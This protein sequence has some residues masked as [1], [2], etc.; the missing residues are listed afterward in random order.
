MISVVII[1]KNEEKNIGECLKSVAWCDEKIVIDDY[2]KDNTAEIAEKSGAKVIKH[3]LINFSDQRNFGLEKARNDWVLFVDADERVSQALWYEI[4]HSI[5]NT[6]AKIDGFYIRRNDIMWGKM[7]RY[8]ESSGIKLMR[9]AR[10]TAGKWVGDVHE[11]WEISG[12]SRVLN[13]SLK[14]YPHQS[15]A[16]FLEEINY[17]TEIRARELHN[18][19]SRASWLSVIF[20]PIAKFFQNYF[21]KRGYIDGVPGIITAIMMS[22]HSFLVRGKLWILCST[23]QKTS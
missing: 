20:Y 22:F 8:G 3:R 11:R 17:Y 4:D 10:R 15:V 6:L 14:H 13:H 18:K 23:K 16:E 1:T 9:L 12:S 21:Y 5:N 7:L 19:K 2:S